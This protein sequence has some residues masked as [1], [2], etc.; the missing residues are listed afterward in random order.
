MADGSQAPHPVP[1][2]RRL[3]AWG[4]HLLTASGAVIAFLSLLAVFEGEPAQALLWLCLSLLVDGLDGP[5]ARRVRI[6]DSVPGIDGAALDLIVDFLTYV[7]VPAAILWRFGML[8]DPLALPLIALV[9]LSS[10]HLFAKTDMKAADNHFV[11]F[12]AVWSGVVLVLF[13]LGTPPAL[14][15]AVTVLLVVLTFAPLKAVHPFRVER[16]RALTLVVTAAWGLSAVAL[17]WLHPARP[18][19]LLGIFVAGGLYLVAVSL[20]RT[21]AD[22]GADRMAK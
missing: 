21:I 12:P 14:N 8:P 16:W 19:W 22:R 2:R 15:A 4:V 7:F 5:L 1:V 18:G 17:L 6:R 10:L 9:L 11:G 13:L 20:W 3:A